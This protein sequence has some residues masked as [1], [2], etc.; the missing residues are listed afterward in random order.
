M[1]RHVLD[2]ELDGRALGPAR[3]DAEVVRIRKTFTASSITA[4]A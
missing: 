2:L 4:I 1:A 3:R